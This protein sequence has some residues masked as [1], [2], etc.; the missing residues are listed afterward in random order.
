ML[1]W[2]N[3]H[4]RQQTQ[5]DR[6]EAGTFDSATKQL[7]KGK[8]TFANGIVLEETVALNANGKNYLAEGKGAC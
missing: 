8:V 1:L 2:A 6:T 3:K 5:N 4:Y 7:T